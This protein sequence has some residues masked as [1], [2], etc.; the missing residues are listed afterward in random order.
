MSRRV[1][2]LLEREI[3][4]RLK[5][6]DAV[7]V[8]SPRGIDGVRSNQLRRKLREQGVRMLVVRN[9]LA[10]RATVNPR[11]RGFEKLLEGPSALLYGRASIPSIARLLIEEKKNNEKLELRGVF[12]DGEVYAGEEGVKAASKLPTR[13]EAIAQLVSAMLG[14][15]RALAGA[16]RGPGGK[17]AGV[18]KTIEQRGK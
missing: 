4:N 14:P 5:D 13:E 15:G 3:S 1:K 8:I 11:L 10:R 12:F 6:V 16:I 2:S 17:I 9:T 7:A 18:L